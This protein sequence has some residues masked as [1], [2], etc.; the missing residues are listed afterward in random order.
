MDGSSTGGDERRVPFGNLLASRTAIGVFLGGFATPSLV[1]LGAAP[2][3]ARWSQRLL[4]V[5]V[6]SRVARG[7]LGS[8]C[9]V[10]AG[11]S[12]ICMTF[13]QFGILKVLLIGMAFSIGTVIVTQGSTLN[14]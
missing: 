10:T 13:V 12:V 11:A 14:R 6:S 1:Q 8:L 5:G 9:V 2:G 7:L 3:L 4:R